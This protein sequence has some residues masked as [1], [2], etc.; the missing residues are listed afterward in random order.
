MPAFASVFFR[1][2]SQVS[3]VQ[4][5]AMRYPEFEPGNYRIRAAITAF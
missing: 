4:V 1:Q 2:S 5:K 3:R